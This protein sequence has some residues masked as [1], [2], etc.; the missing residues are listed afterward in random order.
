MIEL[1]KKPK[2]DLRVALVTDVGLE[3]ANSFTDKELNELG[4]FCLTIVK[5]NLKMKVREERKSKEI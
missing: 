2:D 5:N 1:S 4:L 3:V